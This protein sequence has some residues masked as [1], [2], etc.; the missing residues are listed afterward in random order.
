MKKKCTEIPTLKCS[1]VKSV[2]A[3]SNISKIL[4]GI[5][6]FKDQT[7]QLNKRSELI[8]KCRHVSK[9]LLKAHRQIFKKWRFEKHCSC[10]KACQLSAL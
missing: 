5:V 6:S 3:Y 8:S 2:P 4:S 1:L 9:C 7:N 10:D